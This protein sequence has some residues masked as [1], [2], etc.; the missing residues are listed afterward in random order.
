MARKARDPKY[1]A[2]VRE[3]RSIFGNG[4]SVSPAMCEKE[5]QRLI[6]LERLASY[7][8]KKTLEIKD[9]AFQL[10]TAQFKKLKE[11]L[12]SLDLSFVGK[13]SGKYNL[14]V[15]NLNLKKGTPQG[16]ILQKELQFEQGPVELS[17]PFKRQDFE[18]CQ[19]PCS[20]SHPKIYPIAISL[21]MLSSNGFGEEVLLNAPLLISVV[22]LSISIP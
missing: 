21:F 8:G 17:L 12:W 14:E 1:C 5:V 10:K 18:L 7:Q 20:L 16:V 3:R 4:S 22:N 15:K 19:E 13:V 9:Q 11:D 2:E 6:E